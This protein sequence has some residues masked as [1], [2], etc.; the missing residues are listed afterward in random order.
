MS[1]TREKIYLDDVTIHHDGK[2]IYRPTTDRNNNQVYKFCVTV[3][4]AD[5]QKVKEA[6]QRLLG[7]A[8]TPLH[9]IPDEDSV[10]SLEEQAYL[11][12]WEYYGKAPLIN[13][14]T[15]L[16]IQ[17]Y[18]RQE[19]YTESDDLNI[20]Y[21]NQLDPPCLSGVQ[22]YEYLKDRVGNLQMH[23]RQMENGA[24]IAYCEYLNIYPEYEE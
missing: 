24:I 18:Y 15:G 12:H 3:S 1:T 11:A 5:K 20:I 7:R 23:L 10:M 19:V 16:P 9:F 13:Q 8:A 6:V 14:H 17:T 22:R 2:S 21:F 4:P